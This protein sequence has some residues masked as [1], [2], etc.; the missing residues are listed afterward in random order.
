VISIKDESKVLQVLRVLLREFR[1]RGWL[2]EWIDFP[3]IRKDYVNKQTKREIMIT[4]YFHRVTAVW[5]TDNDFVSL[6]EYDENREQ[7]Y[8]EDDREETLISGIGDELNISK[9]THSLL[10]SHDYQEIVDE[11]KSFK[12]LISSIQ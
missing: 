11:F 2:T 7:Y 6:K 1:V 9:I 8:E 4:M 5:K 12:K 10:D 3:V